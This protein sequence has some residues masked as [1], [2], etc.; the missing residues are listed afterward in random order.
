MAARVIG[1]TGSRRRRRFLFA[2]LTLVVLIALIAISSASGVLAGS[3]SK[4]ESGNDPTLGLGNMVVNTT[5][6]KDWISVTGEGSYV[7]LPDAAA[8][9]SDDSF[10]P[11]QKQDTVCP[12]VEGHKNPPKDD[13]TDVAS[14]SEVNTTD[15]DAH[16]GDVYLYGA[17]I[18]YAPNGNASENI[19]LK[20]GTSGEC[21]E[22]PGLLERTPG[23]KLVAID[24]LGGGSAVQFHVLTWV[25]SGPCFVSQ[26][27]APCW[28]ATVLDLTSSGF[29]EGGVNGSPITAANNPISSVALKAGQFAEFGINLSDSNIIPSGEC[30]GFSQTIWESRSSG[31]SFVSSTKDITIED[32]DINICGSAE[33]TKF[34]SDGGSQEGA[35][36]T[37]YEGSDTSGAVVGSCTVDADGNC[38][39]D[40]GTTTYPPSFAN[41]QP[42]TYTIDESGQPANYGKDPAL[43]D[44]F[45]VDVGQTVQLS[46]TDPRLQGALMILKNSTK[47]D[48]TS[49]VTTAGAEFTYDSSTVIDNG[50]GD[51]DSDIGEVCVS[52]LDLGTYTV[53]ETSPPPGYGDASETDQQVTVVDGTNCTDNQPGAGATATFHNP[54]LAD[55]QV[56]FRDAG[57]GETNVVGSTINCVEGATDLGDNDATPTTGWDKSETH[58]GLDPGTYVCTV[59]VDP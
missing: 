19:E 15:G 14:F 51:E 52:G 18:R 1:P 43:P 33:V 56:N 42:G 57:S 32:K 49:A 3:P 7:H 10:T 28:G 6:N 12:T 50:T 37:L 22:V 35:V 11:G 53:N 8:S 24:Y 16:E 21:A 23:D 38:V 25:A 55:I 9:T 48:G 4:F 27:P 34:G 46:Y 41:L 40:D 39:N 5:G 58:L 17:T 47:G 26:D 31:S 45:T 29:A 2:P 54:P 13:F 30:A 36:F 59:V 44:T 20:Q